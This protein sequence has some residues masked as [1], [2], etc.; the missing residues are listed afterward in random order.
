[1]ALRDDLLPTVDTARQM[2]DDFGF[3]RAGVAVQTVV[4]SAPINTPGAV[5][6]STTRVE[7]TPR[8]RV[9][10]MGAEETSLLAATLPSIVSGRGFR[11]LYEIT[12][13]TPQFTAGGYTLE[14]LVKPVAP[15]A[16]T[17]VT[18]LIWGIE[19]LGADIDSATAFETVK[20]IERSF[21][22]TFIV[23]QVGT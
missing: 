10:Q 2:V 6:V 20:V 5:V 15:T 1:M 18:W 3:R 8:P 12:A 7:I 14:E 23:G 13:V 16:S 4:Y 21:R 9:T 11:M 22:Y 17:T 19:G